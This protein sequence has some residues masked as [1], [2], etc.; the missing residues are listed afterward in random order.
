MTN[1]AYDSDSSFEFG[2]FDPATL[3]FSSADYPVTFVLTMGVTSEDDTADDFTYT[4]TLTENI[5]CV[6]SQSSP[7]SASVSYETFQSTSLQI[8][9][10]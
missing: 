7:A 9:T 2:S 4:V 8:D 6:R 1:S 3:T 5:V 10:F